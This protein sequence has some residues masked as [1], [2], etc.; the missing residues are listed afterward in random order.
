[1][2]C[3][4]PAT[5]KRK[6]APFVRACFL[7]VVWIQA[8]SSAT[9]LHAACAWRS[10]CASG[11]AVRRVL[12]QLPCFQNM[13][14]AAFEEHDSACVHHLHVGVVS[15]T[16]TGNSGNLINFCI[17]VIAGTCPGWGGGVH[18]LDPASPV[19]RMAFFPTPPPTLLS[20]FYIHLSNCTIQNHQIEQPSKLIIRTLFF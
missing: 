11:C 16:G 3:N 10:C 9:G 1:M 5:R 19:R 18:E 17:R 15:C 2:Q 6:C 4:V 14:D 12:Y 8:R 13:L 7:G 20:T